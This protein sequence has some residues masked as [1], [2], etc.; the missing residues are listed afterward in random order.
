MFADKW[1]NGSRA[2]W[3]RYGILQYSVPL[4]P[5]P[6]TALSGTVSNGGVNTQD[7]SAAGEI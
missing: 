5:K 6:Q 3:N 7:S 4:L 2:E 1:K